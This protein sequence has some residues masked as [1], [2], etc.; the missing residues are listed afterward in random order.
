MGVALGMIKMAVVVVALVLTGLSACSNR[1]IYEDMQIR[2]R[3]DCHKEPSPRAVREC[4]ERVDTSYET[5]QRQREG[6]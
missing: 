4:L 1:A 5:Y 6:L 2:Q 3:N